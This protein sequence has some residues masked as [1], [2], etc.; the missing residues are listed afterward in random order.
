L[1]FLDNELNASAAASCVLGGFGSKST[2]PFQNLQSLH[3]TRSSQSSLWQTLEEKQFLVVQSHCNLASETATCLVA[4]QQL[5][6]KTMQT[7]AQHVSSVQVS[8]VLHAFCQGRLKQ[9]D[10][11]DCPGRLPILWLLP[12]YLEK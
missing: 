12:F 8:P 3:Y 10:L 11:P 6:K 2:V 4:V 9:S 5:Q 7:M 1:A